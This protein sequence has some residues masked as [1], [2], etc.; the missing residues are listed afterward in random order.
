MAR[1]CTI[2]TVGLFLMVATTIL[3]TFAPLLVL[4]IWM[5]K[6]GQ[7]DEAPLTEKRFKDPTSFMW[8]VKYATFIKCYVA[9][10]LDGKAINP[11]LIRCNRN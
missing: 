3:R 9:R 2:H 8:I 7:G 1:N 4:E 10:H 6:Q 11:A 5:Q